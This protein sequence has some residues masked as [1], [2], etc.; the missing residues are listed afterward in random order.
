LCFKQTI[1]QIKFLEN[2]KLQSQRNQIFI[3]YIDYSTYGA[4]KTF[5]SGSGSGCPSGLDLVGTSGSGSSS[6]V[7][8]PAGGSGGGFLSH[9]HKLKLSLQPNLNLQ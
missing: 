7:S 9:I 2:N 8:S 3:I 5:G 1:K 6:S 4:G